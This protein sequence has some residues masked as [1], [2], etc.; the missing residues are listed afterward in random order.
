MRPVRKSG[1]VSGRR[2]LNRAGWIA[3]KQQIA[4]RSGGLCEVVIAYTLEW[5]GDLL[6]LVRR[7]VRLAV[8]VHH[9]QKRSAGGADDPDNCIAIC[10]QHH[11]RT[12]WPFAKGRLVILPLGRGAFESVL[13]YKENKWA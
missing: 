3:L 2:A 12:D 8:D 11:D 1:I 6:P 7:C 4:T 10:R 5:D 13:V 9:V